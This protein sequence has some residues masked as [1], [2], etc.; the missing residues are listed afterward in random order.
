MEGCT[1]EGAWNSTR[2]L[3][4]IRYQRGSVLARASQLIAGMSPAKA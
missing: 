1:A 2:I 4:L 3:D